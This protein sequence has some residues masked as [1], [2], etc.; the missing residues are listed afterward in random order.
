MLIHGQ[1]FFGVLAGRSDRER[2]GLGS[3]LG[4]DFHFFNRNSQWQVKNFLSVSKMEAAVFERDK[5]TLTT[6]MQFIRGK[7]VYLISTEFRGYLISRF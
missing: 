3:T 6:V 4:G 5:V 7:F 2:E 1:T